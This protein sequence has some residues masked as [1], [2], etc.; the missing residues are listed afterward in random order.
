MRVQ[1][2][3]VLVIEPDPGVR[4]VLERGLPRH[5]YTVVATG[6]IGEALDAM[7]SNAFGAFVLDSDVSDADVTA[8][9]DC[10]TRRCGFGVIT[11]AGA[12]RAREF[13][14]VSP[15]LSKPYTVRNLAALL[16]QRMR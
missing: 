14:L 3:S 12:P 11:T 6:S 5:G 10:L 2:A 9:V 16:D 15:H 7:T 1:I 8:L 4:R 13:A